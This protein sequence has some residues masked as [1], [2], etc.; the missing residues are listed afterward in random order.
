L[1]FGNPLKDFQLDSIKKLYKL[2][3]SYKPSN[4][5]NG[6]IKS[7]PEEYFEGKWK[8]WHSENFDVP[9]FMGWFNGQDSDEATVTQNQ[10][11]LREIW[12]EYKSNLDTL[13]KSGNKQ[14]HEDRTA[15]FNAILY[16][17]S[18][19]YTRDL[20]K[21]PPQ[22]RPFTSNYPKI[23]Q[24]II[25]FYKLLREFLSQS[26]FDTA[27]PQPDN[28]S[29]N[30]E[31][32]GPRQEATLSKNISQKFIAARNRLVQT[33]KQ[34]KKKTKKTLQNIF[35]LKSSPRVLDILEK[36]WWVFKVQAKFKLKDT[37]MILYQKSKV[38]LFD[39]KGEK[40][41]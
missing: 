38:M 16:Y 20:S 21:I 25:I 8:D 18:I 13:K 1:V 5:N 35:L 11:S 29:S 2:G 27:S 14:H 24:S 37:E 7:E 3:V 19:F 41:A 6:R 4:S 26:D 40:F 28:P 10:V 17:S 23:F 9:K 32:D 12:L 34:E 31:D 22:D 15:F 36:F 33:L 39:K 30:S